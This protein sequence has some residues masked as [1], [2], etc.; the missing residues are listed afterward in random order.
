[1][2]MI[3]DETLGIADIRVRYCGRDGPDFMLLVNGKSTKPYRSPN[4]LERYSDGCQYYGGSQNNRCLRLQASTL[5]WYV[6]RYIKT[7]T[8]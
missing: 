8:G 3:Q 7:F 6:Y 1:M 4:C 5:L 2:C